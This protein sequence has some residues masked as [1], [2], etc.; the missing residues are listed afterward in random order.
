M[1]PLL[2]KLLA[3]FFRQPDFAQGKAENED[4]SA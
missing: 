4:F 2:E 1:H 3:L